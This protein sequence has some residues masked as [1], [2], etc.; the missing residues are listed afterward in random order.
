M[1]ETEPAA[2]NCTISAS[3]FNPILWQ[4]P[5]SAAAGPI[6]IGSAWAVGSAFAAAQARECLPAVNSSICRS[7]QPPQVC[8]VMTVRFAE[9][10][11]E[12]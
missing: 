4:A 7:W 8:A 5:Q 11:A 3:D 6:A 1:A 2:L 10:R 12:R 9:S